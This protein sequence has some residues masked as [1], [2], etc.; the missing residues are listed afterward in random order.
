MERTQP[1]DCILD[2]TLIDLSP[3]SIRRLAVLLGRAVQLRCPLCGS[4]GIF[5]HPWSLK[6][7]SPTCE[8][9]FVQ[10]D[11]YFFGAT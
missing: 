10:E 3:I 8:Y 6:D 4:R 2:T 5:D 7:C 9:T 1:Q 11:G